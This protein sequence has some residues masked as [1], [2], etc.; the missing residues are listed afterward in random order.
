MLRILN[1]VVPS[2]R[3]KRKKKTISIVILLFF[4]I[5]KILFFI[6][7]MPHHFFFKK[8]EKHHKMFLTHKCHNQFWKGTLM[9][10]CTISDLVVVICGKNT[11]INRRQ[12]I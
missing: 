5:S 2:L 1:H 8:T 12:C 3:G 11:F 4:R 6:L 10:N 7:E 9:Q